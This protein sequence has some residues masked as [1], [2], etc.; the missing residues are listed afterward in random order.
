[1]SEEDL[2]A[3]PESIDEGWHPENR[4][5]GVSAGSVVNWLVLALVLAA[6]G[7]LAY[8][9]AQ[10]FLPRWWAE[11][12]GL[13]VAA[14]S[15]LGMILG[16]AI[17]A[18]FTFVPLLL[19]AQVRRR[20]FSWA[21]RIIIALLAVVLALPNWLTV[22]VAIGTS[23]AAQ[24]GRIIMTA[25]APGFRN[26]SAIGAIVGGVLGLIVVG[27]SMRLSQ[28]RKRVRE[29]KSKVSDLEKRTFADAPDGEASGTG[30]SERAPDAE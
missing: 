28:Q 6:V 13:E 9:T 30:P 12:L 17:G 8:V 16:L 7:Y 10:D 21:W 26:G 20:V 22:A 23:R 1:M 25:E 2:N 5:G 29:L 15:T 14:D 24:D 19:L 11:Q 3:R 18:V 27:T 4:N